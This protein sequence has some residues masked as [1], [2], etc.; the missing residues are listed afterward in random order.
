[1]S[2]LVT[3]GNLRS[4]LAVTRSLG[5]QGIAVTIADECRSSLAGASRYCRASIRVPSPEREGEPF[6]N[7]IPLYDLKVAAGR[8]S[9][10]QVVD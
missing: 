7:A 6:V 2:V 8:F 1:M 5:R 10:E 3:P 4:S 9:G